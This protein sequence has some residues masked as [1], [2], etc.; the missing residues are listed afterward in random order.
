[1]DMS[2]KGGCHVPLYSL[3][4]FIAGIY[5]QSKTE[6]NQQIAGLD[7]RATQ[8]DLLLFI[9][10]NPNLVQREIAAQMVIDPSLL[11]RDLRK[12][13]QQKLVTR[14]SDTTDKRVNR[15]NLTPAGIRAAERVKH[16][17]ISWWDSFFAQHPEIDQPVFTDQLQKVY[18]ALQ[19]TKH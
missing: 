1:M 4:K 8:S 17:M 3:S 18:E 6:F 16:T 2:T 9:Y 5:R 12:L 7:V 10:D 15:I 11:A 13:S 14:T 19:R